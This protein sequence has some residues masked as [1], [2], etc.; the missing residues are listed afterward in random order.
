MRA[1]LFAALAL[2][3]VGTLGLSACATAPMAEPVA[4]MDTLQGLQVSGVA[5]VKVGAFKPDPS[6]A[7]GKDKSINSRAAAIKPPTGNSFAAYLGQ[8]LATELNAAGKLDGASALEI[9]GF[10]TESQLDSAGFV[11]ATGSLGARFVMTRNGTVVYDKVLR[12]DASWESNFIGAIAIPAAIS[13]YNALYAKL[14]RALLQ[15]PDFVAAT[16]G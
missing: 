11:T 14:A 3:I 4:S 6:L 13:N 12:V 7:P 1:P 2:A 16:R 8:T 10:L 5:P 9:T 15:D